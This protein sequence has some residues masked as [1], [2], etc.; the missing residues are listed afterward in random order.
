MYGEPWGDFAEYVWETKFTPDGSS[1]A[2]MTKNDNRYCV[3]LNGTPWETYFENANQYSLS[4]CGTRTAAVVQ[5]VSLAQADIDGFMKGV[6]SVA[7]DGNAW[8]G[9]YVNL[10]TPTFS[11]DGARVAA[12]ARITTFDYTIA[13][14]DKPWQK[15][16]QQVWEPVFHPKNKSVAAPVRAGGKWG[17]AQD[18]DILWAPRYSQCLGLQ[19]SATGEKLWAMVATGFGRFTIACNNVPWDVTF[20]IITDMVISPDGNRAAILANEYNKNFRIVI[21]GKTWGRRLRHGLARGLFGR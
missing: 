5:V 9:R 7:V 20:P 13:V 11:P 12:Q 1:I 3:S 18:G 16:F 14:D 10:F 8:S 15:T 21:N 19:Y 4:P 6:Y 17:V 2:A